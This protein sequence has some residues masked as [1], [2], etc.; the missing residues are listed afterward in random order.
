MAATLQMTYVGTPFIYYGVE[1]GMWGA[2]DPDCRKPMVW[3]DLVYDPEFTGPDGKRMGPNEVKFDRNLHAF[4][5]AAI[6]LRRGTPVLNAGTFQW[7]AADDAANTLAFMRSGG[8]A[9]AVVVF[10]RSEV[11][12]TIR[13][14]APDGWPE[15]N[16][17]AKFVSDGGSA[18][19]RR[20]GGEAITDLA[21]LTAAVFLP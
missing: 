3:D 16:V 5:K 11:P 13:F 7:L 17:P 9:R 18:V 20:M 15:A 4:F 1:A 21:P 10:N 2:N 8:N 19:L 12:Q 6:A 14:A